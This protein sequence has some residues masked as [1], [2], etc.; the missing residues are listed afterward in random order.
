M[1]ITI[2]MTPKNSC[3]TAQ[4]NGKT[5]LW[6]AARTLLIERGRDFNRRL[7]TALS[8]FDPEDIHD[9][10]VS[11]RRLR[12]GL[13]LFADCYPPGSI[14]RLGKRIKRVTRLLGE[15][16]NRDEA[17]LF[18]ESLRAELDSTCQSELDRMLTGFR[19]ERQNEARALETGLKNISATEL[20]RLNRQVVERP[21]L[22]TPTG[23]AIDPFTPLAFFARNSLSSRLGDV[24]QLIPAASQEDN[25]TAQHQLRIAVKH[26]RYRLEILS[27]LLGNSYKE[28]YTTVK[29]YQEVLGK[30]HDLDVFA[31]VSRE[32]FHPRPAAATI[33]AA[34]AG[35]WNRLFSAFSVMLTNK[36]LRKI[37][38]SL[39]NIR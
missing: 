11:S 37:N 14:T 15:I 39:R 27:F 3:V 1:N 26:F 35:Q 36:P 13:A 29:E 20:S 28:L 25:V 24:L 9:L 16:R 22:F 7:R 5:P 17:L 19:A 38:D 4:L 23:T 12:E 30:M 32:F 33:Q 18:F 2:Q 34:I 10:R 21:C 6:A 31:A 8:S